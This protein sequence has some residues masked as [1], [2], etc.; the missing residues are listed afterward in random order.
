MLHSISDARD[1]ISLGMQLTEARCERV[2]LFQDR[3][4]IGKIMD[5]FPALLLCEAYSALTIFS[6]TAVQ[7]VSML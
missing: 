1:F 3:T 7:P 2:I 6:G 5:L 4:R